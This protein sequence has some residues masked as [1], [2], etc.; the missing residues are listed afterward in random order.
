[1]HWP[2]SC[3]LV[4]WAVPVRPCVPVHHHQVLESWL[5]QG[6]AA[7]EGLEQRQQGRALACKGL[8][9]NT[10][11]DRAGKRNRSDHRRG[12]KVVWQLWQTYT[13]HVLEEP[14][15]CTKSN[16]QAAIPTS[17]QTCGK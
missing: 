6:H 2:E 15:S 11:Q 13:S 17:Q 12:R 4:C 10:L 14:S 9:L 7:W 8:A 3:S 16:A 1:M 5:L